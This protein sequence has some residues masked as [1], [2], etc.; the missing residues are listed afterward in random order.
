MTDEGA[1]MAALREALTGLRAQS[2]ALGRQLEGVEIGALLSR[3]DLA[4]IPVLRKSDLAARQRAAPP[5]GGLAAVEAGRFKRLFASPGSLFE[6]Q[7]YGDDVWGAAPALAAAGLKAG[8]IVV[9]C[10]SYHLTPGGF[11]METGAHALGCAVIPAG[12]GNTEQTLQAIAHLKP[13]TYCGPPDF[14][15]ILLDKAGEAG[16]DVS[17]I[18]KALVSGAALPATL[19]A[20]LERRGVKTRQAYATAELGVIAYETDAADGAAAPGLKVSDAVLVEIVTPGGADPVAGGKVGEVVVTRLSAHYPLLRFATGDLSAFLPGPP[21]GAR[22]KGWMGR[23]DQTAKIKGLFVH[24]QQVVEVGKRHPELGAVRLIVRREGEQDAMIL[25]AEASNPRS[26]L[27]QEVAATLQS[28]TK[29]RGAV[30]FVAP[31]ALPNDGK[32]IADER[33]T[34]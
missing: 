13:T 14:L 9:N 5:F 27:A 34:Q 8:E 4:R 2:P 33:P 17:C 12:P 3:V 32:V 19:R 16:L 6:P 28:V 11:I 25:V 29:M 20:E 7:D 21:E 22:I 31:G 10:F 1:Q 30:Q 23:A 18:R 24:P 26:D 15:K